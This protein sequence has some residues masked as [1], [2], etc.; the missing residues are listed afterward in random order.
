MGYRSLEVACGDISYTY[1]IDSW[2]LGCVI[3]ELFL[4]KPLIEA[5][6][7][8]ENIWT[9]FEVLGTPT[10]SF[11]SELPL[12]PKHPPNFKGQPWPP[13]WFPNWYG[14]RALKFL[15]IFDGLLQLDPSQRWSPSSARSRCLGD[16]S[17]T[18]LVNTAKG[19]RGA[20][21]IITATVDDCLLA[22]IQQDAAWKGMCAT[23]GSMT[24]LEIGGYVSEAPP[25]VSKCNST[26]CGSPF[27]APSVYS[28][29]CSFRTKNRDW[30]TA[31]TSEVRTAL[32]F[33]PSEQLGTNGQ[34]FFETC[35]S[36]TAFAYAWAQ[37]MRPGQRFDEEHFDGGASL[38]MAVL[39]IYGS[40]RLHLKLD[41]TWSEQTLQQQ[42]GN[43][44]VGTMAAVFHRVEHDEI[45]GSLY[46]ESSGDD[47]FKIV[48]LFR[49]DCFSGNRGRNMVS[50][51]GRAQVFDIVNAVI[52]Q[53]LAREPLLCPTAAEAMEAWLS[54]TSDESSTK[55]RRLLGKGRLH[56]PWT[57]RIHTDSVGDS[58][59]Q[60]MHVTEIGARHPPPRII[61]ET[62]GA[63]LS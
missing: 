54:R 14:S 56:Q 13:T 28:F 23:I 40:R 36:D 1:S 17:F 51:P 44:Y 9:I 34:H 12:F 42:A 21:T 38:L 41:G 18:V 8:I 2:S 26:D 60:V 58:E 35:F 33:I 49:T 11:W 50:K 4:R 59:K 47:G 25:K 10:E 31:L 46:R 32:R 3:A 16:D 55:R 27:A 37:V 22:W 39:T 29:G 5:K 48:I 53:K 45:S 62:L 63:E 61:S 6:W 19:G 57:G 52:A 43:F 20:T 15:T 30:L 24:K 7:N